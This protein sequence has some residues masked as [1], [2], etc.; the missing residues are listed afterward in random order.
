V[1]F[2]VLQRVFPQPA[3]VAQTP[4]TLYSFKGSPDGADPKGGLVIGTDGALYGTTFAGGTYVLGTVF[5]LTKPTGEPWKETVLHN[6]SGPDGQHPESTL[7]GST[8]ALY[9]TTIQIAYGGGAAPGAIFELSPPATAGG[10]WA[11]TVL[12]TFLYK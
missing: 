1:P 8:G 9:G 4:T 2:R 5:V 11:E 10:A 7:A 12:Y 6:F 3:S